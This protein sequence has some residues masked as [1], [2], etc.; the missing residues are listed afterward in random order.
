MTNKVERNLN[1]EQRSFSARVFTTGFLS[2]LLASRCSPFLYAR[3]RLFFYC[4]AKHERPGQDQSFCLFI[5]LSVRILCVC[6]CLFKCAALERNSKLFPG[7]ALFSNKS[8]CSPKTL[9][10]FLRNLS[11]S[12][13]LSVHQNRT[14]RRPQFQR[15]H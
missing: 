1:C 2:P 5:T 6:V 3:G 4:D 9:L 10:H 13:N 8:R 11:A 15:S 12:F 7:A 14:R